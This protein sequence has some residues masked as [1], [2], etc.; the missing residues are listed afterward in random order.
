M[1]LQIYFV[2]EFNSIE[3]IFIDDITEEDE[4]RIRDLIKKS[5][6]IE[7]NN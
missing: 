7:I 2:Y 3:R 1:Y 5:K 4:A 6:N